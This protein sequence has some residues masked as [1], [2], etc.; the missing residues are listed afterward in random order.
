M[1]KYI[2]IQRSAHLDAGYSPVT[3][4][5]FT[6][7]MATIPLLKEELLNVI[8]H[9]CVAFQKR[10]NGSEEF[11]ELVGLQSLSPAKNLFLLPDGRWLG[12]YKPAFYRA[13]PFALLPGEQDDQLQLCINSDCINPEPADSDERFFDEDKALTPQMQKVVEFLTESMRS[14]G[15]TLS[16]CKALQDANLIVPWPISISEPGGENKSQEKTLQGLYHVDSDR[17]KI[18]PAEKLAALNTSGALSLAY[19]Q[20]FSEAR[21][22]DLAKLQT[23]HRNLQQQQAQQNSPEPDLDELFGTKDE[24]FSF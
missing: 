20:L 18:L 23:A 10:N 13:E 22:K 17:L 14:R 19:A 2:A 16:L 11:Y 4:F 6:A 15:V 1:T 9:M 5:S 21:L 12:G 8:Q 24:L 7:E 3:N